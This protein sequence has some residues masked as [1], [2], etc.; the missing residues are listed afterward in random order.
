MHA[1]VEWAQVLAEHVTPHETATASLVAEAYARGGRQR[2]Q[3]MEESGALT[4]GF[5]TGDLVVLFPAV[6]SAIHEATPYLLALLTARHTADLLDLVKSAVAQ[7]AT[8]RGSPGKGAPSGG[9]T[10]MV[11]VAGLNRATDVVEKSLRQAGINM[12]EA[13][14]MALHV[15]HALLR[16][17]D[18]GRRFIQF[19]TEKG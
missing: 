14:L 2:R 11:E 7:P 8:A 19:I 10:A 4:G 9:A 1:I 13:E 12:G 18:N 16:D 15:V 17:A 6:L 5:G 3:L